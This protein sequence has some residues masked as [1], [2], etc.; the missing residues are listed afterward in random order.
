MKTTTLGLP[1][2]L[3]ESLEAKANEREMGFAEWSADFQTA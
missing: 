3:Y 1:E 2:R